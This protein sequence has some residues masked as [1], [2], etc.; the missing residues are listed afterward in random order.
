VRSDSESPSGSGPVVGPG[1]DAARRVDPTGR[2]A[3]FS[4]PPTAAPDQLAPGDRKDGR[5]AFYSTGPRR[6]GTVVVICS[7]C[8]IRTRIT[9][10][11]LGVRL[12]SGSLWFP[13]RRHS[14]WMRCPGCDTHQWCRIA[15]TG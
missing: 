4:A 11:N 9:L 7:A 5:H 3:L 12:L 15:W 13:G 14:R 10:A 6:P 8:G 1:R 2:H